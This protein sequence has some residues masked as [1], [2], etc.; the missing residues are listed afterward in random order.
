MFAY[1]SETWKNQFEE[2]KYFEAT[3]AEALRMKNE[4]N[5]FINHK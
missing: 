2:T 4:L 5:N 1:K 3:R